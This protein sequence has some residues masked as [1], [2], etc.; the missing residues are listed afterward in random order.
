MF[1]K[2]V[3]F[4]L[5]NFQVYLDILHGLIRVYNW[6]SS[7]SSFRRPYF[8]NS[9]SL[10]IVSAVPSRRLVSFNWTSS[11]LQA[12]CRHSKIF[13]GSRELV[14]FFHPLLFSEFLP[15]L[16]LLFLII[17]VQ[18]DYSIIIIPRIWYFVVN[19]K[20]DM[21]L[22]KLLLLNLSSKGLLTVPSVR[23]STDRLTHVCNL[24]FIQLQG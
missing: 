8:H 6:I 14:S 22:M 4:L 24:V 11:Y 7:F 18:I 23:I 10:V 15:S 12:L 17:F 5:K 3:Y 16:I 13:I 21:L 9:K 2:R 19:I 1:L 20:I